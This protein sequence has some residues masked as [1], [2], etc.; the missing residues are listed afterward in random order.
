MGKVG[1]PRRGS[2]RRKILACLGVS[3][4]IS[5]TLGLMLIEWRKIKL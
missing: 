2:G 5:W 4:L 1:T 3:G